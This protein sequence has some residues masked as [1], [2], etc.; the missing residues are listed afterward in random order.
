MKTPAERAYE[1][2]KKPRKISIT[3][4]IRGKAAHKVK[5]MIPQ[6]ANVV[7]PFIKNILP[8]EYRPE[9]QEIR[10]AMN[11]VI[12]RTRN[13]N[14]EKLEKLEDISSFIMQYDDGYFY[15][16]LDFFNEVDISKLKIPLDKK[17]I[18][19]HKKRWNYDFP[20][21]HLK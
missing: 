12:K 19:Y 21:E 9:I 18:E 17:D 3:E 2:R 15:W 10:R 14:I 8:G 20:E 7:Y 5:G 11:V 13:Q 1:D 4:L 16:L 6:M